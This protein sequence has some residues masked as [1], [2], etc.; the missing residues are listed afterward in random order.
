[1]RRSL[2]ASTS[3]RARCVALL[4]LLA[5]TAA[6]A[7]NATRHGARGCFFG[8]LSAPEA[9]ADAARQRAV[10]SELLLFEVNADYVPLAVRLAG[11]LHRLGM[12]NYLAMGYDAGTC[13]L[14]H[15]R[16]VCCGHSALLRAHAGVAAW[17]M[18]DGGGLA[19]RREKTILFLVKLQSMLGALDAGVRHVIHC[20]LDIHLLDNP[21][22]TLRGA[23]FGRPA[24][25][26]GVDMPQLPPDA[27]AACASAGAVPGGA[28]TARPRL[29][30]GIVYLASGAEGA[31]RRL[32]NETLAVILGRFDA[33]VLQPPAACGARCHY[34]L[35]PD[36]DQ[37]WEQARACARKQVLRSLRH[38]H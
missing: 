34:P 29:N 11:N 28:T 31:A 20:D 23:R 5:A 14:L 13:S 26:T 17:Q 35:L 12:R 25:A 6:S 9:F 33:A 18:G 1:M 24:L 2:T 4:L 3:T 19:A 22:R 16:R 37:L 7:L 32:L 10:A 30:T 36:W 15:A 38:V 27:A 21:F 8:D